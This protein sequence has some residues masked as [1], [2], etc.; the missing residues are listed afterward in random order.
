MESPPL[1]FTDFSGSMGL[2]EL[3]KELP[4]AVQPPAFVYK[5]Q[6][7]YARERVAIFQQAWHFVCLASDLTSP[8]EYIT[9]SFDNTPIIVVCGNDQRLRA[10][11]NTCRHRGAPLTQCHHGKMKNFVC[12]FHHWSYRLDGRLFRAPGIEVEDSF[13]LEKLDAN[14]IERP[15]EVRENLVFINLSQRPPLPLDQYLGNYIE[16]VAKPH[17]TTTMRCVHHRRYELETNWKLYTE[18]DMETLHTPHVHRG[19]IGE[20]PV[21]ILQ[22]SGQWVGVFN[23]SPQTVAIK[24][25]KRHLGL[26]FSPNAFGDGL[27]GTHFCIILPGFFIVNAPDCMWWIQK[28]PINATRVEVDVGYCFPEEV[29]GTPEYEE[30]LPCYR[31]RLDQ[32]IKEDDD[33][34]VYQHCGLNNCVP[35]RYTPRETVVHQLAQLLIGTTL[36]GGFT[37]PSDTL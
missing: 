4:N 24:P 13:Q 23:R 30:K 35:G 15:C 19:S 2:S 28:T 25:N 20:Q 18:V 17:A 22:P 5:S 8:G 32:V 10:F 14:L 33:I 9:R 3:F 37:T 21:E 7:W 27:K 31:E 1:I 26:P 34:V 29:I 36:Q 6:R 12:P 16:T 11:F